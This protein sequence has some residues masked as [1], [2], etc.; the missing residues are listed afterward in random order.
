MLEFDRQGVLD[1]VVKAHL[2]RGLQVDGIRSHRTAGRIEA[3]G[4]V[5]SSLKSAGKLARLLDEIQR[6]ADSPDALLD[7]FCEA[8][9][10]ADAETRLQFFT[11]ILTELEVS[12]EAI[13]PALAALASTSATSSALSW[14]SRLTDLRRALESPRM[15]AFR[16]FLSFSGG[17]KFLLDLRA[18]V[19]GAQRQGGG[20][21]PLDEEIAY[22]FTSWFQHGFLFLQEITEES[23]YRQIRF[24]KDH[25]LVHPAASL[26][27]MGTRLGTDRRCFALYHRA[28]PEEPVVF[29]EVALTRR[30]PQSIH[31]ILGESEARPAKDADTAI[32]YS[33]N[34]TQNGLGGLGLGK[35]LI[36]QV[37]A[38]IRKSQ[39]QIKTFATLS[40]VPRFRTHYLEPILEGH[41]EAFELEISSLVQ[42]FSE[43]TQRRMVERFRHDHDDVPASFPEVL[44]LIL[45]DATWIENPVYERELA[46]PLRELA[47]FYLTREKD[48]RGK[49]LNPVANFHMGNGARLSAKNVHFGGNRT[50]RG[51]LDSAGVMVSYVYSSTWFHELRRSARAALPWE[52]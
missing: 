24:L 43:K 42:H 9:A 46:T 33:I 37:V 36:F 25:D 29:I 21:T 41:D 6:E 45:S 7:A 2:S 35:T 22:L 26:E 23:S 44:R 17:L 38:A 19:L 14:T 8:Y 11:Q 32:F 40:P 3:G 15:R 34:N 52:V 18:D 27:E 31:Q 50:E 48:A 49:P 16:R 12:K 20:L 13:A 5:L 47:F 1:S 51:L 28:M 30:L 4:K 39:P 10:A